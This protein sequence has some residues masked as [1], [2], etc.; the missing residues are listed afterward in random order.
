MGDHSSTRSCAEMEDSVDGFRQLDAME[1]DS[2][3][4]LANLRFQ[5]TDSAEAFSGT[6]LEMALLVAEMASP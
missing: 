6:S 3:F 4:H 5:L 1:M 2:A